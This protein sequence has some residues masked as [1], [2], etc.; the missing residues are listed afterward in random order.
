M[1]YHV[2]IMMILKRSPASERYE[3]YKSGHHWPVLVLLVNIT[4]CPQQSHTLLPDVMLLKWMISLQTTTL[5]HDH[6]FAI[7]ICFYT[8]NNGNMSRAFAGGKFLKLSDIESF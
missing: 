7:C 1:E 2:K 8:C 4:K 5:T 6:T 3:P